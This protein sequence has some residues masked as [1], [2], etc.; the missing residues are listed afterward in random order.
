MADR[1]TELNRKKREERKQ[2]LIEAAR[3]LFAREGYENTTVKAIVE[4]A[5]TSV[6]N[7]YFYFQT[8]DEI[9]FTVAKKVNETVFTDMDKIWK[10]EYSAHLNAAIYIYA[11]T[12]HWYKN[13]EIARVLIQGQIETGTRLRLLSMHSEKL[14]EMTSHDDSLIK[15]FPLDIL[16]AAW[17]GLWLGVLEMFLQD[18]GKFST[19]N[20]IDKIIELSLLATGLTE[21]ELSDTINQLNNVTGMLKK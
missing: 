11:F 10:R 17:Q 15:K 4:E 8:K 18:P 20:W 3:V 13:L 16:I 1:K 12:S 9:L 5:G 14:I 2:S 19:E 7:F 6:G 21:P